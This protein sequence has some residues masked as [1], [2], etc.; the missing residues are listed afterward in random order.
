ME[1][2]ELLEGLVC[3]KANILMVFLMATEESFGGTKT[4]MLVTLKM[5]LQMEMEHIQ[6]YHVK[7]TS[8]VFGNKDH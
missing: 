4:I 6:T 8:K 5:V 2:E 1:L 7:L 3:M